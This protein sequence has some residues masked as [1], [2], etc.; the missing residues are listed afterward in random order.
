MRISWVY[1]SRFLNQNKSV[2]LINSKVR[3]KTIKINIRKLKVFFFI[4]QSGFE[5]NKW[6][7]ITIITAGT[8][9]YTEQN[10]LNYYRSWLLRLGKHK[11]PEGGN[12]MVPWDA[13]LIAT[14][15]QSDHE[16]SPLLARVFARAEPEVSPVPSL[17]SCSCCSLWIIVSRGLG[18]STA[19]SLTTWF[20][21]D[22]NSKGQSYN[23]TYD[24]SS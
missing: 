8:I 20:R 22:K 10:N 4:W 23:Y 17:W 6:N 18:P 11:D 9:I 21:P 15:D 19:C 24:N 12:N 13:S 14:T 7:K 16:T 3:R 5:F 2:V 1:N